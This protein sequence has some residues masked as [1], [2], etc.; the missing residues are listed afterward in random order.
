MDPERLSAHAEAALW[1]ALRAGDAAA[2]PPLLALH[3]PY[4]R[5]VAATYYRRRYHD[6]VEF[7]DYHQYARLGLLEAMER[8]DPA[9]GVQFRS[10]AARRMHGAILDGLGRFTERQQQIAAQQQLRAARVQA[11]KEIAGA[12]GGPGQRMGEALL[13][14]VAEV[15]LGLALCWL[16]EDTGMVDDPG[17]CESVPF[18]RCSELRQLRDGL[19]HLVDALPAQERSV[20]RAHYLQEQPFEAIARELALTRGRI[21]QIHKQALARLRTQ[22]AAL[23]LGP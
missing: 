9:R 4:A 2:R 11:V 18:Y 3:L 20:V 6:E 7:E 16:L 10:Y 22:A 12:D 13:A 17:R 21:S 15:G 23:E 14:Y 19:H 5:V 8:Y 1:Q